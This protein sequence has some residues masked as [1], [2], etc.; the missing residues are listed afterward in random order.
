MPDLSILDTGAGGL[1]V[2]ATPVT[3]EKAAPAP[4][5]TPEPAVETPE[6]QDEPP[7]AKP[8]PNKPAEPAKDPNRAE[9]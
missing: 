3:A 7:A 5:V 8:E 4:A 1:K 6:P 2:E 9:P